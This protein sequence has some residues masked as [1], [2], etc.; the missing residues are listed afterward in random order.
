M[1]CR[2]ADGHSYFL[3]YRPP[4]L[5][6]SH[7]SRSF[8]RRVNDEIVPRA[9]ATIPVTIGAVMVTVET[10]LSICRCGEYAVLGIASVQPADRLTTS[11]VASMT[12]LLGARYTRLLALISVRCRHKHGVVTPSSMCT[13][14]DGRFSSLK[15]IVVWQSHAI[16][17]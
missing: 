6:D 9:I 17:D 14:Q 8:R 11:P 13:K 12:E 1:A 7:S 16:S 3:G 2:T 4:R 15:I 5:K 10:P